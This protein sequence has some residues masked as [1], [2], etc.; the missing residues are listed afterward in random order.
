MSVEEREA[1]VQLRLAR[2]FPLHAPPHPIQG[3]G[4]YLITAANFEHQPIMMTVERRTDF[5]LRLLESL[6][7][8]EA[9][10]YGWVVLLNHYHALVGIRGLRE[11]SA[12]LKELHGQTARE[13][14][15]ADCQSGVRQVWYHFNDRKIRGD[16]HFYRALNY[17]HYNPVK[18]GCADS[19]YD[20]PWSSVHNYLATNGRDWLREMW[21]SF[22]PDYIGRGWDD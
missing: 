11:V 7:E 5:E 18:H 20:W 3:N 2:G 6:R 17:V 16:K 9:D 15:L 8:I 10:V 4:R 22:R 13:W 21:Q 19:V 12:K 14:N 1:A